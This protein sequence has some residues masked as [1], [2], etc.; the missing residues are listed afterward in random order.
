MLRTR[1]ARLVCRGLAAAA[2]ISGSSG[3]VAAGAGTRGTVRISGTDLYALACPAVQECVAVGDNGLEVTF[4]PR[5]PRLARASRIDRFHSVF[6]VGCPSRRSCTASANPGRELTFDPYHAGP[7]AG[8]G[9]NSRLILP[10]S[11]NTTVACASVRLCV[12]AAGTRE[13]TFDPRTRVV[14]AHA[15]LPT[16]NVARI[17]CPSSR[18]CAAVDYNGKE[19]SFDPERP[20][21]SNKVLT[22]D[23][24]DLAAIACPS[25][26]QCTSVGQIEGVEV[27]F[28]PVTGAIIS[29][30]TVDPGLDPGVYD[31]ACPSREQCTLID[32][33][34]RAITFDP[35]SG[36]ARRAARLRLDGDQDSI[37]C[38]T[39]TQCTALGDLLEVTFD[40]LTT[41]RPG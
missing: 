3:A 40:P 9:G 11:D 20:R 18:L 7:W 38:P 21:A 14:T 17:A 28:D 13:V 4:D 31:L 29:R 19:L 26:R 12:A 1:L 41:G 33:V 10:G 16:G 30:A 27:S 15:E 5:S 39:T 22:L 25:A 24:Y 32:G 37:A 34:A 35:R 23:Q 6:A 36:S 2:L 8:P